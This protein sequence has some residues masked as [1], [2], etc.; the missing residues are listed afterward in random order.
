MKPKRFSGLLF[1]ALVVS[2][3]CTS[4]AAEPKHGG[5]LRFG[6]QKS[7]TALNPFIQTQSLNHRVRSLMYEGLLAFDS[8]LEPL[9]ALAT[10]WNVSPDATLYTF[11]LRPGVKFHNGKPVTLADVKWSIDYVQD[12][13]NAAFG[14]ADLTVINQVEIEE[15][16]RIRIRLKFPFSPLLSTFAGIHILPILAKD[17]VKTGERPDSF[18]PGTGPFRFVSWKPA[19][20]LR[21]QR[22]DG[23]WQKGLPYV[24]E[25]RFIFGLDE[26]TRLNAIRSGDM[27][28]SE[29]MTS[30]QILWIRDG[31]IPGVGFALAAAGNHPRMGIN[32]CRSPFNNLKV[33][34]AFAY[35]LDKQEIINGTFSGLGVP[36]NQKIVKGTKW[37][38]SEVADRKQD[39]GKAKAL[40]AEAGYPEGL[41][42]TVPGS[43]G[44]QKILQ[45]IQSQVRK[46]GIELTLLIRDQATHIAALNKAEFEISMSGGATSADPDLAYYAHYHTPPPEQWGKGGRYQPC[47]SNARVDHLLEEARKVTDVQQRRRMYK[48]MIEILQEDVADIP[49]AFVPVGYAFQN[50]VKGFEPSITEPYSYGN[51][52]LIKTWMDK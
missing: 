39:I 12:P 25:I 49:I 5:T 33:R 50:T 13:K 28:I 43:P 35:A 48:E 2:L 45:V 40:L 26:T 34:Q 19:Q 46:A 1:I 11:T 10:S 9:P 32:H 30:D 23:Y 42:V 22:F 21:V 47:Y 31:K 16:D 8:K 38:A 41:K 18:P 6:V 20:E 4:L 15:P 37:F 27:D 52:G 44:S 3:A 14:R 7:L 29:E 17:S 24:D 51:G 36:T